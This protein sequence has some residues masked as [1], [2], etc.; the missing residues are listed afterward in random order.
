MLNNYA[1]QYKHLFT[2]DLFEIY[3]LLGFRA[4]G[5][6]MIGIFLPL[7]LLVELQFSLAQ[8]IYFFL[9]TT[10]AFG[11][12][13]YAAL[14]VISR[15]GAKHAMVGSYLFLI[16]GLILT[17][18]LEYNPSLYLLA[19]FLQGLSFGLFWMGFHIDV[20]VHSQKKIAGKQSG[21]LS[22]VSVLGAV[23]GPLIGGLL[24]RYTSFSF[25]F[26]VS[27]LLF[28]ISVLPLIF[29][30]DVY[31][32]T[33]FNF[34]Y[35]LAP[36][37]LHYFFAYF[38][39]GIKF[40]AG[41]IFWPIFIFGIFGS[42]LVLGSYGTI[43][44]L[45]IGIVGYF[46]GALAD[47]WKRRRLIRL[48]APFDVLAWIARVFVSTTGGVFAVGLFSGLSSLGI[49]IPLMAKTYTRARKEEIAA[50]VFFREISLRVG[51][52]FCLLLVLLT[53]SIKSAFV[54]TALSSVLYLFF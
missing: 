23:V 21:M 29:S 32:K 28:I 27:I 50:F 41:G 48:F 47:R 35:L 39:Q 2:R 25:L 44:T 1:Q 5:F 15:Y 13:S 37:H 26:L 17:T 45:V 52:I 16:F 19:A 31:V 14:S 4:L 6:S 11:L 18:L 22:L 51:E 53:L 34:K 42:Y 40:T 24:L 46:I 8:V 36:G 49:D 9:M 30:K 3:F 7:F 12:A 38:A 10:V 54:A 33:H 20:A 43:V